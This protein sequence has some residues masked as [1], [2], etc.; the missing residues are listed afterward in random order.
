MQKIN[1]LA[2]LLFLCSMTAFAQIND[3]TMPK[4]FVPA[5]YLNQSIP[6]VT[7]PALDMAV[8]NQENTERDAKGILMFNTKIQPTSI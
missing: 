4:S 2:T 7:T 5:F 3:G 6:L 8:I 1:L